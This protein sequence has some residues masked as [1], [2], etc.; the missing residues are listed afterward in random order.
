MRVNSIDNQS[1]RA[2]KVTLSSEI[3][4]K[5]LFNRDD[6]EFLKSVALSNDVDVAVLKGKKNKYLPKNDMYSIIASKI[7]KGDDPKREVSVILPRKSDDKLTVVENIFEAVYST[8][9][10]LNENLNK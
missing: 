6:F 7:K 5:K 4:Q 3:V 2:G 10:K 1:F 8:L 9:N